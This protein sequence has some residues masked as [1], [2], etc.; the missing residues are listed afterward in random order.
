MG[1]FDHHAQALGFQVLFNGI[2]DLGGQLF[3]QLEP[4]SEAVDQPGQL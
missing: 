3:L 4:M 1:G 2:S